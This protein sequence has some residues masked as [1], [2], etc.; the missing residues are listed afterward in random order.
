MMNNVEMIT[1]TGNMLLQEIQFWQINLN[2]LEKALENE[3]KCLLVL[4][5][6]VV[7]EIDRIQQDKKRCIS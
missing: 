6:D 4:H 3:G 5:H 7:R 2:L 1:Q